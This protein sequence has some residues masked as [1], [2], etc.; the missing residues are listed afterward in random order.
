MT[1][2]L[3]LIIV[4]FIFAIGGIFLGI[5]IQKLKNNSTQGAFD[6]QEAQLL[7]QIA[8]LKNSI[9]KE[10][11]AK[12]AIRQEKDSLAIR[13]S[14]KEVDFDNL[15]ERNKEQK[16]EVEQLQVK[17][18]EKFQVLANKITFRNFKSY[19]MSSNIN[20]TYKISSS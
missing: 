4:A 15:L 10:V 9:E 6:A 2:N 7:E 1:E 20:Y 13:L 11:L 18:E 19:K 12:E 16:A 8:Q 5:Y 17:F 3:L 14:R